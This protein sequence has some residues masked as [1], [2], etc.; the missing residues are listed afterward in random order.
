MVD[1]SNTEIPRCA[2]N[3]S[4]GTGRCVAEHAP[5]T[6]GDP[7]PATASMPAYVVVQIAVHDPERYERYK[8]LAQ[9]SVA[10]YDGRY[11][12]RG[13]PTTTLEGTWAP[14]RLVILEFPSVERAHAWWASPEYAEGKAL[15]QACAESEL[16]VVEG[17]G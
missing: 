8:A 13:G 1:R 5:A 15:R 6:F 9:S 12:V 16:L 10:A 7:S 2:R 4:P 11:I 14:R 17:V 3:D